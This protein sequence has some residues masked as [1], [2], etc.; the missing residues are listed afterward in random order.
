MN[1]SVDVQWVGWLL[2]GSVSDKCGRSGGRN[3][4]GGRDDGRDGETVGY[5]WVDSRCIGV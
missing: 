3:G 4:D 2:Y 5:W 1:G